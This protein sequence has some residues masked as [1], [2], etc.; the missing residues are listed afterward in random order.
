MTQIPSFP[1]AVPPQGKP[2]KQCRQVIDRAAR[3]C[4]YCQSRQ[5][6][7]CLGKSALIALA[8]FVFLAVL[9]RYLPDPS[10]AT[11]TSQPVSGTQPATQADCST[12]HPKVGQPAP[13]LKEIECRAEMQGVFELADG[14]REKVLVRFKN[15]TQCLFKGKVTIYAVDAA[16]EEL[17]M[18]RVACEVGPDGTEQ[19]AVVWM[20]K[21]NAI[22]SFRYETEGKFED[23]PNVTAEVPFKEVKKLPDK[24]FFFISTTTQNR[25][26]LKKIA[27]S[28]KKRYS[29]SAVVVL[30]FFDDEE[31]AAKGVPMNSSDAKH[32]I[33]D[34]Y[35][36]SNLS[37]EEWHDWQ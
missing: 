30:Y 20:K 7:G 4:P 37:K 15:K 24:T 35:W 33:C 2:C 18:E 23:A 26:D 12:Q 34:Y 25:D 13:S 29:G 5:S 36:Y 28:Y 27:E 9:G 6:M 3:R 1:P 32:C 19:S 10:K 31:A 11:P 17:D 14:Q 21:P 16:G 8:V 22:A